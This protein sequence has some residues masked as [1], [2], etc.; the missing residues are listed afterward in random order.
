MAW[1]AR[2][3]WK[4]VA[5]LFV[6]AVLAG[7]GLVH[8][9]YYEILDVKRENPLHSLLV[10]DLG[11]ITYFAGENQFPVAWTPEQNAL[12]ID[13][14]Y[15]PTLWD[16]YWTLEPCRFVMARLERKDDVIFGT[17]RLIDAWIHAIMAHPGDYLQHR[18]SVLWTFLAHPNLTL[19]LFKLDIRRVPTPMAQNPYFMALLPLHDAL[20]ST[21]IYRMGVWLILALAIGAWAW[22]A[23]ATDAGAFSVYV[24]GSAAIYVLSYGVFAVATDFRYG[25]WRV[26]ACLAAAVPAFLARRT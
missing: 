2:F 18:L 24:T 17:P 15:K 5:L 26:L 10:F 21:P 19:E 7:Y 9:V 16:I 12:L 23:R 25:Y 22:P 8:L 3:E 11:G 6:P 1:P 13:Q 14:C 20:K 4:R